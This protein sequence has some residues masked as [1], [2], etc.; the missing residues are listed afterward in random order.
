M[1]P[2]RSALAPYGGL[3]RNI[4]WLSAGSLAVKPL[5]FAFITVVCAR[6]L[7]AA[8]YGTF[9]TALSLASLAFS[10]VGLGVS[11]YTVR[12]VAGDRAL[13]P[14]FFTNFMALRLGLSI[15][16]VLVA[17]AVGAALGYER[18]LLAAVGLACLY[19]GALGFAEYARSFFQAFEVLKYQAVSIVAEKV[20]VIAGGVLLLYGAASPQ[21]VLLG[22]TVGMALTAAGTVL[23]VGRRLAS[24]S[25]A[26]LDGAFVGRSLRPLIPFGLAGLFGMFFYRLDTVMVEAMLGVEAA[27]QYGLAYRIFDAL[28]MLRLFVVDAATYPRLASLTRQGEHAAFRRL[29]AIVAGG[30]L[31]VCLLVAVTVSLVATRLVDWIALDPAL[32]VAGPV[33]RVLT[34]AFP[35]LSLRTLL[36]AALVA[37]GHQRF[38]ARVLGVGVVMNAALNFVL[39]PRLGIEGAVL[40]TLASEALLLGTYGLR[41]RTL[42]RQA[43][44]A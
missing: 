20:L 5:W 6:S 43:R 18:G 2:K 42:V 29:V 40:A 22:M 34:W 19:T 21:G 17:L 32:E 11:T 27:G 25:R 3:L 31:A 10:F 4:S 36:Y 9:N 35:I 15:V 44:R 7:G 26:L 33:L 14:R 38:L 24:P 37:L 41:Y 8:G 39:I 12:E 13:A 16:A 23:W 1:Q 30:L 28:S